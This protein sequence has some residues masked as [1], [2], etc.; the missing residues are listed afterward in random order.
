MDDQTFQQHFAD[1]IFIFKEDFHKQFFQLR[2]SFQIGFCFMG[3][4]RQRINIFAGQTGSLVLFQ[5]FNPISAAGAIG[6]F[7]I[8]LDKDFP[9]GFQVKI[10]RG[11]RD[12]QLLQKPALA[13]IA[14]VIEQL[15]QNDF[16]PHRLFVQRSAL[17]RVLNV[18]Q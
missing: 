14:G 10:Q 11:V 9:N 12:V 7:Q 8:V 3:L 2:D 18:F 13:H 16:N 6:Q 1:F 5:S 4:F 15:Q 17:R